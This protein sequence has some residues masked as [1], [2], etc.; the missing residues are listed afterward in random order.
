[1]KRQ[2]WPIFTLAAGASL[3][4]CEA[5]ADDWLITGY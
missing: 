3:T 5:K 1:M 4:L 2:F